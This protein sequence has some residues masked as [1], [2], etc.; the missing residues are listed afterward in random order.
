VS[1]KEQLAA[2]RLL[3]KWLDFEKAADA[4]GSFDEV[5]A[6]LAQRDALMKET[7]DFLLLPVVATDVEVG[8]EVESH[9][10]RRG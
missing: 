6:M 9:G 3:R 7:G 10:Q 8:A 1:E 2:V 4:A 5:G